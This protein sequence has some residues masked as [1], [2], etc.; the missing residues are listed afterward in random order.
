MPWMV[1]NNTGMMTGR[2]KPKYL[3]KNLPQVI[4]SQMPQGLSWRLKPGLSGENHMK[5]LSE[6]SY[7][8][9]NNITPINFSKKC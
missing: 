1:I 2:E 7:I 9:L 5:W 6:L 3:D 8:H 4:I